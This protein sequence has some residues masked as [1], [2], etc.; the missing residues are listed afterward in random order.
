MKKIIS[1]LLII[2]FTLV[3]VP[4]NGFS[5]GSEVVHNNESGIPD[6]GLYSIILKSLNRKSGVFT[7]EEAARIKKIDANNV[8][9]RNVDIKSLKGIGCLTGLKDIDLCSNEITDLSGIESL[10]NLEIL[11]LNGNKL[12]GNLKKLSG[13]KKLKSLSL[14]ENKITSLLGIE[15][16]TKLEE[17]NIFDNQVTKLGELKKLTKLTKLSLSYNK[18]KNLSGIEKLKN[19]KDLDAFNNKLT[20]LNEVKKLTKMDDLRVSKNKIKSLAPLKNLKNLTSIYVDDN[21]LTSLSPLNKLTKLTEISANNNK[22]TKVSDIGSLVNLGKLYLE[23]NRLTNLAGIETLTELWWVDFSDNRL[24][25]ISGIENLTKLNYID[26]AG[27]KLKELPDMT[28]LTKLSRPIDFNWDGEFCFNQIPKSEFKEKLPYVLADNSGWVTMQL[29]YQVPKVFKV[30]SLSKVKTTTKK[31]TGK[32][33]KYAYV[34]MYDEDD[35]IIKEVKAD[36]NGKFTF[37]GLNFKNSKGKK[38]SI[39]S[40]KFHS[41]LGISDFKVKK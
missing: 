22:L 21:K 2:S 14:E 3:L 16:L 12:T 33:I 26:F 13:L 1:L 32:T 9:K 41:R 28:K 4:A 11:Y 35:N 20:K 17:L 34:Q 29:K 31:I 38:Y 23:G 37:R 19:L 40:I 39:E 6:K 10:K 7:K 5:V 27:N 30:N 24:T 36:K 15:K 8:N 25:S 18:L